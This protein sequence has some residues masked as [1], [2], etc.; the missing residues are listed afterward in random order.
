[1]VLPPRP[2]QGWTLKK[3]ARLKAGPQAGCYLPPT[4]LPAVYL[5]DTKRPLTQGLPRRTRRSRPEHYVTRRAHHVMTLKRT[6]PWHDVQSDSGPAPWAP[7]VAMT[8]TGALQANQFSVRGPGVR[9]CSR[10]AHMR[11]RHTPRPRPRR[12]WARPNVPAHRQNAISGCAGTLRFARSAGT[13]CRHKIH[14][15]SRG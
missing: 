13:L 9:M 4:M 7:V 8:C 5:C 12:L 1:M 2:L 10:C 11:C 6:V 3:I 15:L 14:P